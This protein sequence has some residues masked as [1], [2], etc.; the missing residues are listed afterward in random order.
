MAVIFCQCVSPIF[1]VNAK[2]IGMTI[3]TLFDDYFLCLPVGELCEELL[4]ICNNKLQPAI[5]NFT[6][7]MT[8]KIIEHFGFKPRTIVRKKFGS[9]L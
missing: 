8:P 3:E 1:V 4:K 6:P 7:I 9:L 5:S 2:L